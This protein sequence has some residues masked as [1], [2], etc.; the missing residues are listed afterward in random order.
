L[1]NRNTNT[2]SCGL[3]IHHKWLSLFQNPC[4][5][6]VR[7]SPE[8]RRVP[9]ARVSATHN[10]KYEKKRIFPAKN[11]D[12]FA[13]PW[14]ITKRSSAWREKIESRAKSKGS[15]SSVFMK[16]NK[17]RRQIA[18]VLAWF[19]LRGG[20]ILFSG[21]NQIQE[22]LGLGGDEESAPG[23]DTPNVPQTPTPIDD[24]P[25]VPQSP[26]LQP[27]A[28]IGEGGDGKFVLEGNRWYEVR[29][30]STDDGT[31]PG[32]QTERALTFGADRPSTV[33]VLVVAG[34]GGGGKV[35]NDLMS[36]GG[37]AGGYIYVLSY[38]VPESE[39]PITIP[40]KVGAGGAKSASVSTS[41]NSNAGYG[42]SGGDS[43]FGGIIAKGGGGGG[44][45]ANASYSVGGS[46][47]SGGGGSAGAGGGG[48]KDATIPEDILDAVIGGNNG[49]QTPAFGGRR[50]GGGGGAGG[51]ES[52]GTL[53]GIGIQ[54]GI[55]GEMRWY[56][57][58]GAGGA[59]DM[60][61]PDGEDLTAYGATAGNDGE[62]N[63]GDGGSGAGNTSGD[64]RTSGG[65][66][67]SGIV[68]VRFPR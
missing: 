5:R 44:N 29:T 33:E 14:Y 37:G 24:P 54:C 59:K 22:L 40:V 34:G 35:G 46:G 49:G 26:P 50:G 18:G 48:I 41:Q 12:V 68:I 20:G 66:G 16:K 53:G 21:C 3:Q 28:F 13:L 39:E 11:L 10:E 56:A 2:P 64:P 9:K 42:G 31:T 65:N 7:L 58:G 36:G 4:S 60:T 8:T 61:A 52:D 1:T 62:P 67:G 57:G 27:E 63:T 47:G 30:F 32:S 55:S 45:H 15:P 25:D 17:K 6:I 43:A 38:P 19:L 23:N 51:S